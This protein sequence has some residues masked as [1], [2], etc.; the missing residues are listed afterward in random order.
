MMNLP[1]YSHEVAPREQ[2]LTH[3]YPQ[4]S[5]SLVNNKTKREGHGAE[6][7][8][9]TK[10]RLRMQTSLS[11]VTFVSNSKSDPITFF[12]SFFFFVNF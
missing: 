5:Y 9:V 4:D 1:V 7:K 2:R 8:L 6:C 12:L 11:C 3:S 10:K